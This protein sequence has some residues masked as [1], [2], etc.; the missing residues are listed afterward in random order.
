[1]LD[2]RK[3]AAVL[4]LLSFAFGP[5]AMAQ[6]VAGDTII[7]VV[8]PNGG[9]SYTTGQTVNIAWSQS[10]VDK[11]TMMVKRDS[12][13][14]DTVDLPGTEL[15]DTTG[16]YRW[17]VPDD[18][19][20][21]DYVIWLIA[22]H[23]GVDQ[24]NDE[25]DAKF[26]ITNSTTASDTGKSVGTTAGDTLPASAA[27]AYKAL[28]KVR[29]YAEDENGLLAGAQEGSGV[30]ISDQGIILTNFH[31]AMAVD[32]Y[33]DSVADTAYE[34][35]LPTTISAEPTC[36]YTAALIYYN[37]DLDLALLQ[38]APVSG[39]GVN[40]PYPFL[41]RATADNTKISDSL[42]VIGYPGIGG[43]TVT[44]SR[45]IVSGKSDKYGQSWIKTDAVTSFGNSG[46]AAINDAGQIIGI[47]TRAHSDLL[48][49]LGFIINI[50][51]VNSWIDS[52]I[53]SPAR[54]SAKQDRMKTFI[55]AKNN[56][57]GANTYEQSEPGLSITKDPSWQFNLGAEGVFYLTNDADED[58]GLVVVGNFRLPYE[59]T[60]DNI[61]PQFKRRSDASNL[62]S[63]LTV[64]T[65][66]VVD[67]NG[68]QGKK[69]IA[70][71]A[72][73]S[74]KYYFIPHGYYLIAIQY[75]YGKDDKDKAIVD[76]AINTLRLKGSYKSSKLGRYVN[77]QPA[78][79]LAATGSW[80][81]MALKSKRKPLTLLSSAYKFAYGD[82]E[83]ERLSE[84]NRNL[85]N[86]SYL[87]SQIQ[88][89]KELNQVAQILDFESKITKSSAHVRLSTQLPDV[90]MLD[91]QL[92]S[93]TDGKVLSRN[94]IWY[95]RLADAYLIPSINYYGE[96]EAE[97][98]KAVA[99]FEAM[100]ATLEVSGAAATSGRTVALV[101]EQ[102][103]RNLSIYGKIKGKIVLRV[104]SRGEAY[105]IHP[106]DQKTYYLGRSEDAFNVMR[107]LG[108]GIKNSDLDKIPVGLRE[109][110]GNDADKDGLA[111]TLEEALGT[112]KAKS[113][114]DGDG[115]GDKT[116]LAGG[117]NPIGS[118]KKTDAAFSARQ[119][120][121]IL[122]A[123]ERKG[124]AWY[125]NPADGKRYFLG[126]PEDAYQVMR[127]LGLGITDKDYSSLV[128]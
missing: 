71:A 7:K 125:V 32:P 106:T 61:Y 57:A 117:Y 114:S 113:D 37:R 10:N 89:H 53:V 59:A 31:V 128:E 105:Y 28:V 48:G 101:G 15:A 34:I 4:L 107:R 51:S 22:Y 112:D 9:E 104:Q 76:S 49:S 17:T 118:G 60:L 65:N 108:V 62:L 36:A 74:L 95:V 103:V 122:L 46:G 70:S 69:I 20:T 120:G 85:S 29:A 90:V 82:I 119:K 47:P 33:D 81:L 55:R 45:G 66:E 26:H 102:K 121:K 41:P 109:Q 44:V 116:E 77:E 67:I 68:H 123:V 39:L 127:Q 97:Y 40:A 42:S 25:S 110:S 6:D 56:A 100:L 73:E 91:Y 83:F 93:R 13:I 14:Y 5:V 27:N 11:I 38:M 43:D 50:A 24:D 21:G 63:M 92:K 18:L 115:H 3:L 126:R 98:A 78:F 111:D 30:L 54:P 86:E 16:V 52:K 84:D 75:S 12:T 8:S 99:E 79:A 80:H 35:C 58:G 72:G 88:E 19:P 23:T 1:M 94:R 2:L 64:T 124:E 87:E 96:S